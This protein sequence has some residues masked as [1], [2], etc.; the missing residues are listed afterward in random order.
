MNAKTIKL[1]WAA[2]LAFSIFWNYGLYS[3]SAYWNIIPFGSVRV[4]D[5][6]A[7]TSLILSSLFVTSILVFFLVKYFRG[8][9]FFKDEI[10]YTSK[11]K[12][13]AFGYLLFMLILSYPEFNDNVNG[14]GIIYS[15][16][17]IM[18]SIQAT[19]ILAKVFPFIQNISFKHV[20]YAINVSIL[21]FVPLFIYKFNR[22]P[23]WVKVIFYAFV[24]LCLRITV[25]YMSKDFNNMHP[26]LRLFPVWLSTSIFTLTNFSLRFPQ[27]IGLVVLMFT[28]FRFASRYLSNNNAI[29]FGLVIGTIPLL[30]HVGLMVDFSFWGAYCVMYLFYCLINKALN[31]NY[32]F[33]LL[34]ISCVVSIGILL[35]ESNVVCIV[36]FVAILSYSFYYEN[37][38]SATKILL[39]LSP[40]F[41][42]APFVLKTLLSGDGY[43]VKLASGGLFSKILFSITSKISLYAAVNGALYWL[44][45][46]P[47]IIFLYK[48]NRIILG[49][50]L[51]FLIIDYTQF[52]SIPM[53]LW[54]LGKYQAEY[55]IPFSV[56]GFFLLLYFVIKKNSLQI[57]CCIL[58]LGVNIFVFKNINNLNK[59]LSVDYDKNCKKLFGSIISG[60][61]ISPYQQALVQVKEKGFAKNVYLLSVKDNEQVIPRNIA[62]Y[63]PQIMASYTI[64]EVE[65]SRKNW[66]DLKNQEYGESLYEK[67]NANNN[68]KLILLLGLSNYQTIQWF[69]SN[70][71]TD[72]ETFYD[73]KYKSKV[74]SLIRN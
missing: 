8:D 35:R 6:T 66:E 5:Y 59:G 71:W 48:R 13:V 15:R 33:N 9:P 36:L 72:W 58:L 49:I 39:Y 10:K 57:T 24:F 73:E 63:F 43:S 16:D 40:M 70:G 65:A 67:I 38:K 44:I 61:F 46:L 2:I 3:S 20:I 37:Q 50:I 26:S 42:S 62:S 54:G 34:A 21:I 74:V 32:S 51:L 64:A 41:V 28:S 18:H 11:D 27:L 56:I 52:Y 7:W 47:F 30:W 4:M 14:D 25:G 23:I 45:F 12:K 19:Y 29:L 55:I 53:W 60:E 1:N 17:G 22:Y 68:I 31:E 69:K